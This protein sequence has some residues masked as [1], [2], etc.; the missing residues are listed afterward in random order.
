M[1]NKAV[2]YISYNGINEPLVQSQVLNYL[3]GISAAGFKFILLTFEKTPLSS[4]RCNTIRQ[5]LS[6]LNIDWHY[7]P[8]HNRPKVF[9]TLIDIRNGAALGAKL[10]KDNNVVMVHAR[11]M[12]SAIMASKIKKRCDI[13]YLY[14]IRGF[15]VDEKFYK[16]SLRGIFLY[17]YAKNIERRV[18]ADSDGVVSLTHAAVNEIKTN[19]FDDREAMPPM[20]VIPTC[21]DLNSFSTG[22]RSAENCANSVRFCYVGS[23]GEGYLAE[24]VFRYFS[25]AREQLRDA[26]LK[27]ITRTNVSFLEALAQKYQISN[28]ALEIKSVK[29]SEVPSELMNVDVGLSFIKPHYSKIASCPTKIAEY[30]AAGIPVVVNTGIGDVDKIVTENEVGDVLY[31]FSTDEIMDS[32]EKVSELIE[33]SGCRKRCLKTAQSCFSLSDGINDYVE[34][35]KEIIN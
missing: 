20:K 33:D 2:L 30:L 4:D 29:H 15:W 25:L 22:A 32:V 12:L 6:L 24:E 14:D 17:R 34:I 13:P 7:L 1:Q 11:S 27:L 3:R 28:S 23:L 18:F 21:V 16:G 26:K 8:Y 9:G 31:T 19:F 5:E 35:Y 10:A